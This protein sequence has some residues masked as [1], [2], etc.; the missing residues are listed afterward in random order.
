[1]G[2]MRG[3]RYTAGML[4][5][6]LAGRHEIGYVA[7]A[8]IFFRILDI[9]KPGPISRLEALPEGWGIMLDDLAAGGLA[10]VGVQVLASAA[11]RGLW[12]A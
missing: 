6:L 9:W 10:L 5:A 7:V 8:F 4:L 3:L 12:G 2:G 11:P 1:M